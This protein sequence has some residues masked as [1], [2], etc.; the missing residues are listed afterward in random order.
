MV[1][2][3]LLLLQILAFYVESFV[4]AYAEGFIEIVEPDNNKIPAK[5]MLSCTCIYIE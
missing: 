2:N 5:E 1:N 3:P 4:K